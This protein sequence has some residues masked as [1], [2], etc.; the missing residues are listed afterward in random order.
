MPA[1]RISRHYPHLTPAERAS[2]ALQAMARGGDDDLAGLIDTCPR[3]L[4]R[5]TD[6][7]YVSIMDASR[8][9][10]WRVTVVIQAMLADLRAE[11]LAA[12]AVAATLNVTRSLAERANDEGFYDG[13]CYARR[14]MPAS[15]A[16][17]AD[18]S[19]DGMDVQPD[20]PADLTPEAGSTFDRV[21]LGLTAAAAAP[22]AAI[23][24]RL[25]T[26]VDALDRFCQ[27]HFALGGLELLRAW[28]CPTV[29]VEEAIKKRSLPP[30]SA[31]LLQEYAEAF[32]QIYGAVRPA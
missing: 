19:D 11:V 17:A 28:K 5:S 27:E 16:S 12:E 18:G 22:I 26:F 24:A 1:T 15:V 13:W 7:E 2:A 30:P 31:R 14:Q 6:E 25:A 8:A 20:D 9:F 10:A 32:G 3:R 21:A 4:Y 23:R 29:G